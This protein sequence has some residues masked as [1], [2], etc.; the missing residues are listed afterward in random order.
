MLRPAHDGKGDA[1]RRGGRFR[2]L[3]RPCHGRIRKPACFDSIAAHYEVDCLVRVS[4]GEFTRGT[5]EDSYAPDCF[6]RGLG[7][8]RKG[9]Q[10]GNG[11]SNDLRFH[12]NSIWTAAL[13][14]L[15]C[16]SSKGGSFSLATG[17]NGSIA[18]D[19]DAQ[20]AIKI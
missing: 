3:S 1:S 17:G 18:R 14:F 2:C 11:N 4:I 13:P 5:V 7:I 16:D 6:F 19:D 9:Q 20:P 12:R 8:T 10:P 15:Q